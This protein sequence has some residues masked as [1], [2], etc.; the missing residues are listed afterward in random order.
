MD[1]Y[2][3]ILEWDDEFKAMITRRKILA[4][5]VKLSIPEFRDVDVESITVGMRPDGDRDAKVENTVLEREGGSKSVLDSLFLIDAN[6]GGSIL[7][8]MVGIEHQNNPNPEYPLGDRMQYYAAKMFGRQS[9][10]NTAAYANHSPS[11]SF[12]IRTSRTGAG[13]T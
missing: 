11:G 12:R 9:I 3:K 2:S 1:A 5:I 10:G 6:V 4:W 13:W 7:P 8:I